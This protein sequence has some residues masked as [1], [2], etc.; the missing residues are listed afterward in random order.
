M[1]A[2][3]YYTPEDIRYEERTVPQ[4][5]EEEVLLR[6][7]A[8][9]L[10]GTDI[11]KATHQT[12]PSG[13]VLGHEISG[14]IVEVGDKVTGFQKGDRVY[15]AHHVPCFTCDFCQRGF[16]TMCSQ[17]S[18]T[19]VEPG[20]FSEYIRVPALHVKHTM[21]K[22]PND[23]SY[24][25][26]A[27]V[28][29]VACCLHGFERAP[30]HPGDVVLIMGAGQIGCIQL[31]LAKHYLA[32]KVMITDVNEN[33]LLKA[34]ELGADA[35]LNP[36]SEQI[37]SR[38]LDETNGKGADLVIISVGSSALLKEAFQVVSRGGTILVFAHFP[39]GDVPIP[40][41]R[42]FNDEV[43]VVGAYSSHPYHYEEAL[44]LLKQEVV[45]T[46]QMVTHRFPLSK[47]LGAI[48]CA[49]HPKGQSVKIMMSPDE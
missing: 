34:K 28:E 40:A 38:V 15:V 11:Y 48:E 23:V 26:G 29:P 36:S 5:G 31:Q 1:K 35:V 43:K 19:N 13:T 9:G 10:C 44:Q 27:M 16:Y 8:C 45:N 22:L 7:R 24:E 37:V 12:V 32:K 3:V 2:A 14:D 25:Q 41:D 17:F 18:A 21:G 46:E 4:I 39:K 33:R 49:K 30:V 6:L 47:L 20:G 42:F